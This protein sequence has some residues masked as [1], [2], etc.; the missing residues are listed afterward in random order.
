MPWANHPNVK[1]IIA[2]N[3]PGQESGNSL[4]DILWGDVNPPGSLPY[5]I[6]VKE[7]DYTPPIF[8]L[9]E[10]VTNSTVWQADFTEGQLID[11]RHF[12]TK[13]ITP[14]Y[15][16]GFG[17][18]YTTF[19]IPATPM[20]MTHLAA[21]IS[22]HGNTSRPIE[23]GG[24]S[25]LWLHLVSIEANVINTGSIPGHSVARLYVL[26]EFKRIYLEAGESNGLKFLLQRR[27]L[28]YRDV[29]SEQ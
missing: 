24:N 8:N 21:N 25:D 20:H 13:N 27:E 17:I 15:D 22:L 5:T 7:T 11:Y 10:P 4:V 9:T 16:F 1:A 6:P 2:A 14:L 26:R 18:S 12:D 23:H 3:L 28:S 29:E 19:D